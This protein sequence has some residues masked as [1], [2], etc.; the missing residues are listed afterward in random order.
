MR[1]RC[2]PRRPAFMPARPSNTPARDDLPCAES[3]HGIDASMCGLGRPVTS[4]STDSC[5]HQSSSGP[6]ARL[7][8]GF[9]Q[10]GSRDR[11]V[12][13]WLLRRRSSRSVRQ[14]QIAKAG[15]RLDARFA[16]RENGRL[17]VDVRRTPKQVPSPCIGD[18]Q[19]NWRPARGRKQGAS[20]RR[21]MSS[22]RPPGPIVEGRVTRPRRVKR[23]KELRHGSAR[24]AL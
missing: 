15:S 20:G 11:L 8:A 24:G 23:R 1:P 21:P 19:V 18:H 6:Y 4:C 9:G 5:K 7:A 22:A 13:A 3:S 14:R 17:V 10:I 12:R 2:R 16:A